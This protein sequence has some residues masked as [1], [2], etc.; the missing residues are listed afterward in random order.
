[1]SE[2]NKSYGVVLVSASS[3]TEAEAIAIQLLQ[4]KLAACISLTPIYSL[5][6]WQNQIENSQEWQLMIKTD[7]QYFAQLENRIKELHSYKIPEIIALPIIK[8]SQPYLQWI[9]E[10]VNS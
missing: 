7:L 10:N 8:G 6:T 9:G 2:T 4:E 3:K 1:M 5:Y